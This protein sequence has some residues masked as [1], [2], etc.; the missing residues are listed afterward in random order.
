MELGNSS[1]IIYYLHFFKY[2]DLNCYIEKKSD[3]FSFMKI[4]I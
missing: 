2:K 4:Q 1:I 3:S